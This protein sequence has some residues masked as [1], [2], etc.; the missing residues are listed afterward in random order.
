MW[1]TV[2]NSVDGFNHV[3]DSSN[4]L[5]L[6]GHVEFLKYPSRFPVTKEF[7]DIVGLEA[8]PQQHCHFGRR[9]VPP[10]SRRPMP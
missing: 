8:N 2:S 5:F 10:V 9:R 4:V 1:D 6:D 7:A 3:P